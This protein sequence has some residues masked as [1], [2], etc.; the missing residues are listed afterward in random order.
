[1]DIESIERYITKSMHN[2]TPIDIR[3]KGRPTVTGL[4]ISA[5]DYEELKRK[6]FWRIVQENHIDEWQ[7]TGNIALA[8]IFYGASFTSLAKPGVGVSSKKDLAP[9]HQVG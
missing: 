4:F 8:K 2:A 5:S 1:M 9:A 7:R 6:N 3:F